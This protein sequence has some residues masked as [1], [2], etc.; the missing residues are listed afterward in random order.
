VLGID[1]ELLQLARHRRHHGTQPHVF[2]LQTTEHKLPIIITAV[3]ANFLFFSAVEFTFD[4]VVCLSE[5]ASCGSVP[6][7]ESFHTHSLDRT[8]QRLC[9][10]CSPYSDAEVSRVEARWPPWRGDNREPV[11]VVIIRTSHAQQWRREQLLP[12]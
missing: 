8:L 10:T 6:R 3:M 5:V 12:P 11:L 1:V 7:H 2:L 9:P 4:F